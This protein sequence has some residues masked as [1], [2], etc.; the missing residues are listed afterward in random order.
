MSLGKYL[1][2]RVFFAQCLAA[3]AIVGVL[4]YLFFHWITFIT[5]HGDEITVPNLS[6]LNPEQVEEKLD[7]LD[8]DY[9]IID[10]VDYQPDFPKLTVVQQEPTAGSK[11]KG[12]RTIYIKLNASTFKMVVVPDLIDKTYRQ[13]VPTL[14]A[15]GLQEGTI[16][17]IPYIGKD[18]V[19]EMW[20]DG[21]KIQPGKK[22]YKATKI[23]LVL[24]DGKVVFDET[25]L[26]SIPENNVP[27][28]SM[29]NEQ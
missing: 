29:S 1:T 20:I 10:T 27:I 28:D 9:Q 13:A 23:D 12:G 26:D 16:R 2:S 21:V 18:M 5:N 7:E 24:G 14:K 15:L 11:V 25:Q 17:Y 6:K 19:L 3:L 4:A 8:L 22:V